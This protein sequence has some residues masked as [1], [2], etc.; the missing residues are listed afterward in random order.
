[1]NAS[2]FVLSFEEASVRNDVN[3]KTGCQNWATEARKKRTAATPAQQTDRGA[4]GE[5]V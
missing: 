3:R 5:D 1:L 2:I 4:R